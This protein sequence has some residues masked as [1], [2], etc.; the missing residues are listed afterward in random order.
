MERIKELR[1]TAVILLVGMFLLSGCFFSSKHEVAFLT[2]LPPV[3][4]KNSF[5]FG[6]KKIILF[7]WEYISLAIGFLK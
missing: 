1:M 4:F 2:S 3:V 7:V 6:N 5:N